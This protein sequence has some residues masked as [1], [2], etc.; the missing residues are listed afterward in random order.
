MKIV[1]TGTG[2]PDKVTVER[3]EPPVPGKG[4]VLVAVEASSVSFAEVQMLYGRYPMRA[5]YPFVLG[6]DLVGTVTALG[7]DA[8][9][10][11]VGQ[12]VAAMTR[13]GAWQTEI[14]LPE[15]LVVPFAEDLPSDV[16]AAVTMNGV[17]AWQLVHEKG[18]VRPGQV[19][20][21]QGA[22]GGVGI[23]L[24]QLAKLAGARVL[25]TASPANHDLVAALGA[26]PIDYRDDVPARVRELAPGGVDVVFDHVGGQGLTTCWRMLAPGGVLVTYGSASTLHDS[27]SWLRP[28]LGTAARLL[29]WS[30]QRLLGRTGGRRATMYAVRPKGFAAALTEVYRLAA[31]GEL[32]PRI[33]KRL[34][35]EEAAEALRLL[36]GGKL[37]GKIVLQAQP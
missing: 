11:Q 4:E 1:L 28:Y 33:V 7:A 13:T 18:K 29:G 5:K 30:I 24:T 12:R 32:D 23:L 14:A 26:E 8:T 25:G 15:S 6:Y 27:G 16:A 31:A 10:V 17:T 3:S 36:E 19:V 35:M 22:S 20:L 2:G 37:G 21:V 34:P 9:G